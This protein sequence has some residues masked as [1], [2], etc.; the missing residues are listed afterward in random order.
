MAQTKK[1]FDEVRVPF[2]QMTFSPDVPTTALGPNEYNDGLNVETD[3]RGIRSVAGDDIL[4]PSVPGTPTFLSGNYRQPQGGKDND[5]WFVSATDE[6]HWWA[7][8]GEG[9]WQDITPGA[10]PFAYNQ[11]T[12][13]CDS[14]NGTVPFF[15]DESN[16]PMFWPEFTGVSFP[17]TAA[18]SA[19][20]SSTL[21]FPVQNDEIPDVVITSQNGDFSYGSSTASSDVRVGQKVVVAGTNTN[22]QT[23]RLRSVA[24]ADN[25]GNFTCSDTL[26]PAV[27]TG[28]IDNGTPPNVG[29]VLT[30]TALTSG[31][32]YS[33]MV[34]SGTGVIADTTITSQVS[35]TAGGIGVYSVNTS[36]YAPS[37]TITGQRTI[38]MSIGQTV[39]ASGVIT[40]TN[41]VLGSVKIV[42][43]TGDFTCNTTTLLPGMSVQVSGVNTSTGTPL[44]GVGIKNNTG[45]FTCSASATPILVGQTIVLGGAVTNTT[46]PLNGPISAVS[47]SGDFTCGASTLQE[48]ESITVTGTN[49]NISNTVLSSVSI[50]DITGGFTCAATT[51]NV[52]QSVRVAGTQ[53][54]TI[55]TLLT[56]VVI[57]G[58]AGQFSCA[59][60]TPALKVGMRL[61]LSGTFGGTGSITGYTDP[62]SYY[63][64]ATNGSTT[65]TLS[66]SYNGAAVTTTVGTPTGLIWAIAPPTIVGYVNPSVGVISATNGTTTFTLTLP[67]GGAITTA[68]G[69]TLGLSYT[70]LPPSISSYT[71]PKTYLVTAPIVGTN[72]NVTGFNLTNLDGT[73]IVT[74]GGV[75]SGLTFTVQKPAVP[76]NAVD[77]TSTEYYV[78]VTNGSTTF[79]LSDK[80]TGLPIDTTGGPQ[81][82]LTFN[83]AASGIVGYVNPTT[84]IISAT[85]DT[86]TFRLVNED[87][88]A[89]KTTGGNP[90]GLVFTRLASGIIGYVNPTN[91]YIDS[92]NGNTRF[93]LSEVFTLSGVSI[94]NINGQFT[95][96]AVGSIL[97]IGQ[98]VVITGTLGGTGTITGYSSPTTYKISATNG[99]TSFTLVNLDDTGIVTSIG[100]PT[101][102]TYTITTRVTT[103]GGTP[104]GLVL[105]VQPPTVATAT[106]YVVQTNGTSTFKLSATLGGAGISTAAGTPVGL[107]FVHTPF[108]IGGKIVVSKI[109]PVGF[110]GT[111]TI[112]DVA[113]NS[114]TYAG[115]TVGPQTVS[116]SV[117]DPQPGMIMYSN[118][119][120][121]EIINIEYEDVTTQRITLKTA[122]AK[123]P[124]AAGD[125][126]IISGVSNYYNG[127]FTVVSSTTTTIDY[128]AV[129]GANY[130]GPGNGQLVSP[131]YCWNY[132]PNWT[133][134]YARFMRLYNT[135]NVGCILVAGGLTVTE[136]DG[137]VKEYPVTVQW[138]QAFGLNEA[139][140]SWQPTITN[141]ANQL[142]VPLRGSVVDAF[143][144]NGQLFLCSYWDTVVFSPLNYSTTSAPILGVKLSNQGRGMLSSN[145]WAN[146]D[147]MVYGIDARDIWQFDGQNF[148]GIGNQ[149]VKNWFYNQLDQN[150]VDRVFMESNTQKNQIEIYYSTKPPIIEDILADGVTD[151]FSCTV[152]PGPFSGSL[153]TELSVVL[154]GTNIGTGSITGY[155]GGPTTYYVVNLDFPG[156]DDRYSFQLALTPQGLPVVLSTGTLRGIAFEFISNGVPN[157]MLSYRHD[158]DCWN[159]PR[160][161]QAA[162]FTCESPV[163]NNEVV[164]QNT[165][166]TTLTGTGTGAH[167]NVLL[168]TDRYQ[169]YPTPNVLGSGYVIGDT[170]RVLGTDIGGETPTNDA[171]I[172]VTA[173]DAVGRIDAVA[174]Y[175][176]GTPLSTWVYENGSRTIVYAR[177]L[178]NRPLVEK[179]LGYN[180]LGPLS[181]PNSTGEYPINSRFRRDNIKMLPDYSGKLLVHRILPEVNNLDQFG[182]QV[183]P[184]FQSGLRTGTVAIKVEGANS[185]G[186]EPLQTTAET[187]AT[188][189]DYPWVQISQNAH[190]IN[191]IEIT[192]S[193]TENIWICPAITWQYTQTEDDR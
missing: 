3:V 97:K 154:T 69:T 156:T 120:P 102:L 95:C 49:T 36:Q 77:T 61:D 18:A 147:K 103:T 43:E 72:P 108:G 181:P 80:V 98:Q 85:N 132:N 135:P 7:N 124:Y 161:V 155:A 6:G 182:V 128:T 145:C 114:V 94:V 14:W 101:G 159:A 90:V 185:V 119:L 126:I 56:S 93:T 45:D 167:M 179:D 57:T 138:S 55:Y 2:Q 168:S 40:T 31:E 28:R 12:N 16:P 136:L 107:T 131:L 44:S 187:I 99:S 129:P 47:G 65:F 180:F 79:T 160:E 122:V 144:C 21:T 188:N 134:Y 116:G 83:I 60:T 125:K 53:T 86:T 74:S 92:T 88:T 33:G 68:V 24:I 117:S 174:R 39:A 164:Y 81:T 163:W 64:I 38:S 71:D 141:I 166:T 176:V 193:S 137:A 25:A 139:P 152:Q 109:I 70:V 66:A 110:R 133:S 89:I 143:P 189:T 23:Y 158:L 184:D 170:V 37:T 32:I 76:D 113:M 162:T 50:D 15:N 171:V 140:K 149:R 78:S 52:G 67:N 172:T 4:L 190:R 192:N 20:G 9:D 191:A 84:Y 73:A 41:S 150:F 46:Y 29:T 177:G 8:N 127:T 121:L 54:N 91:Y 183:Y 22:T 13:I 104:T 17:T 146:T 58:V 165:S 59:A 30:V 151:K 112:T 115:S 130:P 186:Q 123:A 27:F 75:F 100:T 175:A 35:G 82:G 106:Y 63:I 148:V 51:L 118:T 87:G 96:S 11:A 5:F 34:L 105:R 157:M 42:N 48:G 10:G 26:A 142:E 1:A 173:V 62:K 169:S 111:Y 153:H 19:A 178:L